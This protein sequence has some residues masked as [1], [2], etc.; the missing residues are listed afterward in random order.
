[1]EGSFPCF[2]WFLIYYLQLFF[3]DESEDESN[4]MEASEDNVDGEDTFMNTYSDALNEELKNT[5]LKKS[6]VRTDDQLSK[7]NEVAFSY[8][9]CVESAEIWIRQQYFVPIQ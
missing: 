2:F 3:S 9:A 1:M 6:F 8:F 5:T 7:K 4:I